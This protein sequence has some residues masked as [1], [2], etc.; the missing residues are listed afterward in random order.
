MSTSE[1][2]AL[3]QR[4]RQERIK[5]QWSQST[6]AEK[7]GTSNLNINRWE[8]GKSQPQIH[9]RAKLCEVFG[10]SPEELFG[11]SM[12]EEE[13]ATSYPPIWNVPYLRNVYFTGR[14]DILTLLRSSLTDKHAVALAQHSA[15]S[16]L[17]GIG[18]TQVALEYAYRFGNE[19]QAVLWVR[20]DSHEI[21]ISSYASLATVLDLPERQETDQN[22]VVNA[23][24]RWF[25]EHGRW[26]LIFDNADDLHIIYDYLPTR[27]HIIL[28]T[29]SSATGPSVRKI[30]IE[31][32]TQEEGTLFLLRRTHLIHDKAPLHAASEEQRSQIQA[33]W[34]LVDGLPLA[35]DQAASYIE[36]TGCSLADY[37]DLYRSRR[38]ELL[39]QRGAFNRRDYPRSVATTWSLSFEQVEQKNPDAA[40][41]L[42]LTAFLHPDAIPEELLTV[43]VEHTVPDIHMPGQDPFAF[44]DAIKV[45]RLYSLVKRNPEQ[46][47]LSLHRL[48]QEVLKDAM[49]HT[50]QKEWGRY[51][52][53]LVSEIFPE[54]DFSAW[55]KCELYLPHVQVCEQ[56]VE[57]WDIF[58]PEAGHML[59]RAGDYL[60]ERGQYLDAERPLLRS[61]AVLEHVYGQEQFEVTETLNSLAMLYTAMRKFEQAEAL[62]KKVRSIHEHTVGLL[63]RDAADNFHNL[64]E[65]YIRLG[66]YEQAEALIQQALEIQKQLVGLDSLD[67][68]DS[69][70]TLAVLYDH[71]ERYAEAKPLFQRALAIRQETLGPKHPLTA[72]ALSN[73]AFP[74]MSLGEYE[75]AEKLYVQAL[76]I[77][78]EVLGLD[79]PNTIATLSHMAN[80]YS[81]WG[82]YQQAEPLFQQVIQLREKLMGP[83][84]LLVTNYE[85]YAVL[86]H[87][88]QRVEEARKQ[89]QRAEEIRR[90]LT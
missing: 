9:Y 80:L 63:H 36:E 57:Q 38:A 75:E 43:E 55:T 48:V 40:N 46:K 13:E 70:N 32:M 68:S 14:E 82:K 87:K 7:L 24:R 51:A 26:L 23:V 62:Y 50:H 35:L 65:L 33:I 11:T 78:K 59:R 67:V 29:R 52:V 34:E 81:A 22:R 58:L 17:G 10:L 83:H 37:L 15:I 39:K 53:R 18:K 74:Y 85:N 4:L 47:T 56:L 49:E 77:R 60:Y 1:G 16:G 86:L 73:F 12:N 5:R 88:T 69:L 21:F 25:E 3:G 89:E 76:A 20:S 31:K 6:L 8:H 84:P 28:T 61:L 72:T 54:V 71:M 2:Q 64:A 79:H 42:R 19:Y 30:E 41:L 66:K 45:L 90:V 27:G 44:N